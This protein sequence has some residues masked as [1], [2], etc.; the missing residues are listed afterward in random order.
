[1][2]DGCDI[3]AS[4][5]F[6]MGEDIVSSERFAKARLV[7]HHNKSHN[8][9]AHS[10]NCAVCALRVARWL[11]RHGVSVNER[12]A[13][14]AALLHD[15]G[16]T[17]DEVFHS[18]SP[19]KARTHPREGERIAREEYGANDVQLDAIRHHMWPLC[20]VPPK[21][22]EGWVVVAADKHCSTQEAIAIV[23]SVTHARLGARGKREG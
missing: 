18:P 15:I 6:A 14:R 21:S 19:V 20:L 17:E 4:D 5:V 23:R 7:V 22:V 10:V 16:M 8:I 2:S 1:M 12:D 11:A 9:A 3:T 13:V